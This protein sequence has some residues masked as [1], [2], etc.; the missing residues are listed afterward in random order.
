MRVLVGSSAP[1]KVGLLVDK[2][3]AGG[4]G[5]SVLGGACSFWCG[6]GAGAVGLLG[7]GWSSAPGSGC[8]SISSCWANA[9]GARSRLHPKTRARIIALGC[10]FVLLSVRV[11]RLLHSDLLKIVLRCPPAHSLAGVAFTGLLTFRSEEHTSE[12][13][14]QSNLV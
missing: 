14:S 2:V 7:R 3:I 5:A 9:R 11:S 10:I 6:V 8:G 13:Q 12:L 4:A 1:C